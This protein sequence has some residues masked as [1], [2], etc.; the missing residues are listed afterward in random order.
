MFVHHHWNRQQLVDLLQCDRPGCFNPEHLE[1]GS[2]KQN[3]ADAYARGRRK[4]TTH[5]K[6]GHERTPE[7][8][9]GIKIRYCKPCN[10]ASIKR[11]READTK[12]S[13]RHRLVA[14][15]EGLL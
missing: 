6:H 13:E 2:Q 14:E 10:R 8:T 4:L 12:I 1:F 5:C 15:E 7:N 9:G 11:N 3:V